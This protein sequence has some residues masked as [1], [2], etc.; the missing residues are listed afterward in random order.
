MTL[1]RDP[2]FEQLALLEGLQCTCCSV[3]CYTGPIHR[4]NK[5]KRSRGTFTR[6]YGE[7]MLETRTTRI[8]SASPYT[9]FLENGARRVSLTVHSMST[10][11][12]GAHRPA[13]GPG[14]ARRP[15]LGRPGAGRAQTLLKACTKPAGNAVQHYGRGWGWGT[16]LN[17]THTCCRP[18]T[19]TVLRPAHDVCP[20]D[21]MQQDA[22][23]NRSLPSSPLRMA[24][25]IQRRAGRRPGRHSG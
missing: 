8:A 16:C 9:A 1:V 3:Q 17:V 25:Y 14:S 10:L 6:A 22:Q 2:F 21:V 11:Q 24:A 7:S 12:A 13:G 4:S 23:V 5:E 20:L 18:S 15:I 19:T